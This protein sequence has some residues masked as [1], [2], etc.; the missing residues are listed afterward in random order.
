M[1]SGLSA[2]I[3]WA[4]DTVILGIAL[5]MTPF[6][7]TEEAVAL[8]PFVST[9]LHDFCSSLFMLSYTGIRK[10][11]ANVVKAVKTRSG[12]FILLGALLGG[13]IGMTGYVNAIHY[14]GPAYTVIISSMFPA[15]GAF[16]SFV[17]LK[18]K[19]NRLQIAGLIVSITGI[20]L[21]GYVPGENEISN[22]GIGFGC[23]LLCCLGWAA[24]AV[25][26]AYGMK[27]PDVSDE[28]AL[29]LRQLTSAAFYGVV[30]LNVFGGWGLVRDV[31]P[32][33]AFPII[34]AAALF[35]TASYLFYYRA[36]A[37]IGAAKAMA[38]NITYSAWAIAF[39]ALLYRS[40]PD[41]KSV[42][43]AIAVLCGSVV[44]GTDIKD[45]LKR[46]KNTGGRQ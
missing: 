21:L 11:F 39:S 1:Y 44:A 16:L 37:S 5:A 38:L 42:L 28:H 6:V 9:F 22:V 18:E 36:I 14:I 32:T 10:Q 17:F 46:S 15:V 12:K 8:A 33:T 29:Q 23:A 41:V 2:G 7:S 35:G 40:L 27:D 20:I 30:I 26:C 19:M 3:L 24:E 45:L 25:I 13:P 4:L 34:A 31:I 43:C